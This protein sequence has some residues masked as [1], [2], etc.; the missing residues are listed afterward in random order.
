[1]SQA[2]NVFA[3]GERE[4]VRAL[5]LAGVRVVPADDAEAARTAWK[6]LPEE[7]GLVILTTAAH[8]AITPSEQDERLWVVIPE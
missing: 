7:F 6:E 1:M 8:E 4:R 3:I 2:G 5:A